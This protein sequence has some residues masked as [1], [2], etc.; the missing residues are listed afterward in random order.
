MS[1]NNKCFLKGNLTRDPETR[2]TQGGT[3]VTTFGLAVNEKGRGRDQKEQTGF[4]DVVVFGNLGTEV[5]AKYCRK[6]KEV[7]LWGRLA[8][9]QWKAQDGSNRNKIEI[10]VD[11][12]ELGRDAKGQDGQATGKTSGFRQPAVVSREEDGPPEYDGIPF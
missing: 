4:F 6:G 10:V 3:Q 1:M 2:T 5:V 7:S 12:L 8:Y 9:S 11:E